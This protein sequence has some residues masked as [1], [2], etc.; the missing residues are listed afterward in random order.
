MAIS[1]TQPAVGS[2][3]WG[4]NVNNNWQTI[5]DA[6]NSSGGSKNK[7]INGN[8]NVAQRG[9]GAISCPSATNTYTVDRWIVNPATA[10]I[11]AQQDS[12]RTPPNVDSYNNLKLTGAASV[13]TVD[14]IQR[15]EAAIA[16]SLKKTVSFSAQIYNNTGA[17]FT[18]TLMIGTPSAAD[19]FTTVNV[20]NGGGSGDSLQPCGDGQWTTVSW[21]ADISGYTNINYGLQVQLRI[22]SGVLVATKVVNITQIQL[23]TGSAPTNF[24]HL[25]PQQELALCQR[26]CYVTGGLLNYQIF[27]TGVAYS[28][29][30]A[31]SIV[32][33][34]VVMRATPTF[35]CSNVSD[36]ILTDGTNFSGAFSALSL[37]KYD[38][39][40]V[41]LIITATTLTQ[42]RFYYLAANNTT[43]ARLTFN[44]EL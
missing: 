25:F 43:N 33:L 12:A 6:L 22:P 34:P 42:Y 11:T 31:E 20:R 35:A 37:E 21:T 27:G 44:A 36:F 2:T 1:L 32:Q 28:T 40:N 10:Q 16:R 26:Y 29:T 17:S 39:L 24:E 13:G 14:I 5:Q 3:D 4:S 15:I 9:T 41:Q 30:G 8:M 18:P 38:G 7:I 19:D 23:E